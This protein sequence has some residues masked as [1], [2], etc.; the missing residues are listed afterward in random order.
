MRIRIAILENDDNYLNKFIGIINLKYADRITI[1]GFTDRDVAF[2]S[3]AKERIDIFL[4][5]SEYQVNTEDIPDNCVL[6]YLTES[7]EFISVR[8]QKAICKYQNIYSMYKSILSIYAEEAK[9]ENG[10]RNNANKVSMLGFISAAGGV[11]SST[12]AAACAKN[13]AASGKKVLYLNFEKFGIPNEFFEAEG[14]GNISEVLYHV[15]SKKSNLALKLE[16]IVK[17]DCTG[18]YFYDPCKVSLD[19]LNITEE[20]L[21]EMFQALFSE[22][23]DK[24][25]I[26][27][28][29]S[30][31]EM[32]ISILSRLDSLIWLSDGSRQCNLKNE[33]AVQALE[34]YEKRNNKD[35]NSKNYI[36]YNKFNQKSGEWMDDS[37]MEKLGSIENCQEMNEKQIVDYIANLGIF[38]PLL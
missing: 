21:E 35:V 20:T 30:L 24:I 6:I 10:I 33:K 14:E 9:L 15:K 37:I 34:L 23:Y 31:D 17:K 16:S 28:D 11:G 4:V 2:Q 13:F 8:G 25:I 27:C 38:K 32:S 1:Y 3:L 12:M 26:D 5:N 36:L 18:V 22:G 29:F 19:L 7:K